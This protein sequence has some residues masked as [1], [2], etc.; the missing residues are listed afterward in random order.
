MAID[1]AI[2]KLR[3]TKMIA[4]SSKDGKGFGFSTMAQHE[5]STSDRFGP[6]SSG[7]SNYSRKVKQEHDASS[8]CRCSN[9]VAPLYAS[10]LELGSKGPISRK[11]FAKC[12]HLYSKALSS[13]RL[14]IFKDLIAEEIHKF[15]GHVHNKNGYSY[16]FS[17]NP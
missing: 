11:K 9:L 4:S 6:T 5:P 8:R 1:F 16:V 12:F 13:K 14:K 2:L 15:F 7:K 17:E 10:I 3:N